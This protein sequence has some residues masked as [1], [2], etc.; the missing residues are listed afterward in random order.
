[1]SNALGGVAYLVADGLARFFL[2]LLSGSTLLSLRALTMIAKP[3]TAQHQLPPKLAPY[4][5]VKLWRRLRA[6]GGWREERCRLGCRRWRTL[7]R[8]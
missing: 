1:M 8:R 4:V 6:L 5:H 7:S 3:R 2:P